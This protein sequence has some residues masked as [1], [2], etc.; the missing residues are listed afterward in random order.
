MATDDGKMVRHRLLQ[1]V[2]RLR[3]RVLRRVDQHRTESTMF[4]LR[5]TSP[6]KSAWPGVSD[7]IERIPSNS[8][9][10]CFARIVM[11]FSR[12]RSPGQ[13]EP[14]TKT[15]LEP[16]T[17]LRLT[18]HRVDQ[19][20]LPWSTWA[21]MATFRMSARVR[22][23]MHEPW[24]VVEKSPGVAARGRSLMGGGIVAHPE[25]S[26]R[27]DV[28]R[29]RSQRPGAGATLAL[30]P[31]RPNDRRSDCPGSGFGCRICRRGGDPVIRRLVHAAWSG[32]AM[33]IV[34]VAVDTA[35]PLVD[36]VAGTPVT[37]TGLLQ[38]SRPA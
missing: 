34:I 13:S 3:Q 37:L 5:S 8:T 25:R 32:G 14:P 36:A 35:G 20:G 7:D 4:R 17:P 23:L 27:W 6:P 9:E 29:R 26:G 10:V 30:S 19:G 24:I 28:L 22:G 16:G 31:R 2:A 11:P 21:T 15:W 18:Q 12:S 1:D 38:A 33:P